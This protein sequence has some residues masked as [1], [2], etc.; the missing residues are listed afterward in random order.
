MLVT[1]HAAARVV[2]LCA[3]MMMST[4]LAIHLSVSYQHSPFADDA[5]RYLWDGC[6]HGSLPLALLRKFT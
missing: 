1:L 3:K 4:P 6:G 2:V 5:F